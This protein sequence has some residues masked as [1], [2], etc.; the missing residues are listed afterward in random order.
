MLPMPDTLPPMRP[1]AADVERAR[2]ALGDVPVSWRPVPANGAR[3]TR[4]FLVDLPDGRSALVKIAAVDYV[5]AWFRDERRAYE[6]LE[7]QPYLPA[8]VGWD[9]DGEAPLLAIQ[10]ATALPWAARLLGLPPPA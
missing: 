9:G 3:A 1:S 6:A 7:G 4:R 8:L 5:A 10:A 2:R